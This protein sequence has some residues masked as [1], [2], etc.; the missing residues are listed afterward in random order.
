M[1]KTLAVAGAIV[2]ALGAVALT[3]AHAAIYQF[4]LGVPFPSVN[5]SDQSPPSSSVLP[6][7]V[8]RFEDVGPQQVRFTATSSLENS[9][10]FFHRMIFNGVWDRPQDIAFTFQSQ[11]GSFNLPT[12]GKT[13]NAFTTN[14][15]GGFDFQLLFTISGNSTN[16]FDGTES[17]TYLLTC[18]NASECGPLAT[19]AN[20]SP[21]DASDFNVGNNDP[22]GPA[23]NA[24]DGWFAIGSLVYPAPDTNG[25]RYGDNIAANNEVIAAVPEPSSLLLLAAALGALLAVVR[26]KVGGRGLRS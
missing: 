2:L 8:L 17:I 18:A 12:V 7:G 26:P 4:E 20:N 21:L 13:N 9:A 22:S 5:P 11:T 10:E 16:R 25:V 1:P 14:P 24:Y 19:G 15:P 6:I 23:F 3:P